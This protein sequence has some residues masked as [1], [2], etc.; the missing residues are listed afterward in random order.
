[1]HMGLGR[2]ARDCEHSARYLDLNSTL[3]DV[4]RRPEAGTK[5]DSSD[6]SVDGMVYRAHEITV[7][8]ISDGARA[9]EQ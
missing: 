4:Y 9:R 8:G 5:M 7:H 6:E 1:M 2:S 3:S